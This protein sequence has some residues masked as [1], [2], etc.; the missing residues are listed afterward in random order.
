MPPEL[1]ELR[2]LPAA[3]QNPFD[4]QL[5]NARGA[6]PAPEPSLTLSQ[7]NELQEMH[8]KERSLPPTPVKPG[9]FTAACGKVRI[10][11]PHQL[12]QKF[13]HQASTTISVSSDRTGVLA[14][15]ETSLASADKAT[16]T[17]VVEWLHCASKG[18]TS[19]QTSCSDWCYEVL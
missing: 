4:V 8:K 17:L 16:K 6:D 7:W 13:P 2:G 15:I 10:I 9:L 5:S 18:R 12:L 1:R 19:A 11:T 3:I 14:A